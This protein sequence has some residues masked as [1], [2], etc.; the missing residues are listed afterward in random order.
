V[1]PTCTPV[2]H[3]VYVR[4]PA[5]RA[6]SRPAHGSVSQHI[7]HVLSCHI[8]SCHPIRSRVMRYSSSP[9][10]SGTA[11]ERE[12]AEVQER[13]RMRCLRGTSTHLFFA[14]IP[15]PERAVGLSLSAVSSTT[16]REHVCCSGYLGYA[17]RY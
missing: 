11:Q 10:Y 15:I 1:L 5:D 14:S 17:V 2:S 12:Q 16:C 4:R 13:E 3:D 9:L 7:G 8:I 6:V